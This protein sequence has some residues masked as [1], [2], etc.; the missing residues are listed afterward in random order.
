MKIQED[1]PLSSLTTLK[2]G[3]RAR[4]VITCASKQELEEAVRFSRERGL[5]FFVLGGGSNVLAHDEGYEGVII[6]LSFNELTFTSEG[7]RTLAISGASVLWDTLVD[8]CAKRGLWGIENLAGIPG[9][10]GA[11]PIQNIGAYGSELK[12]TL[13]YVEVFDATTGT[14]LCLPSSECRFGYRESRFKH[15]PALIIL[16]VALSLSTEGTPNLSYKDLAACTASELTT[17]SE[18]GNAVRMIR[19][20][21]FP[22]LATHGTAGSFF[23][24]PVI[25]EEAFTS[26]KATYPELPGFRGTNGV[27]ISLAWLLDH[28]LSLKGFRV[29]RAYLFDAQPLVLVAD[30]GATAKDISELADAVALR[31]KDATGISLEREVRTLPKK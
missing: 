18:V 2:V 21:K 7:S 28:V 3:G 24:N 11:S 23:K 13:K 9:T 6:M 30:E 29:N 12:D 1:V 8:A 31:V 16:T 5:S 22:D 20:K 19:S 10:V 15:E 14:S 26:L 27:K 25:S 17:P 4:Y